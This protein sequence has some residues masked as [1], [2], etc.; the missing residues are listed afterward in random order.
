MPRRNYPKNSRNKNLQ[1]PPIRVDRPVD[2]RDDDAY[3]E[4]EAWK[5]YFEEE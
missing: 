5:D 2:K 1:L 4:Y 3:D